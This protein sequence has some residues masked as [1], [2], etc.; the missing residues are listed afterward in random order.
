MVPGAPSNDATV[1]VTAPFD[2][3]VIADV[4]AADAA[5]VEA[6]LATAASLYAD[7]DGWIAPGRRVEILEGTAEMMAARAE[8]LAVEAAREGG[9]PLVDSRVEVARAID[10]V[11]LCI[12]GLRAQAGTE[13]PMNRNAASANRWR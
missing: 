7:R 8:D 10:G 3:D 12:E 5:A 6:A 11:R 4:A 9:K 13:I 2:D 1:S